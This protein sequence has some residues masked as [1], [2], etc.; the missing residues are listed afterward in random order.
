MNFNV[1][2][3]PRINTEQHK[4]MNDLYETNYENLLPSKLILDVMTEHIQNQAFSNK[5]LLDSLIKYCLY[6]KNKFLNF[7]K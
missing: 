2:E 7:V 1:L 4:K 3:I 5:I 6:L